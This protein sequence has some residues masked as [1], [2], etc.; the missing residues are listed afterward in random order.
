MARESAITLTPGISFAD[1]ESDLQAALIKK[2][3][4]SH[5]FHDIPEIKPAVRPIAPVKGY[6]TEAEFSNAFKKYE[7]ELGKWK[8]GE[9]EAKNVLLRR[10]SPSVR[11]QDFRRMIAKQIFDNIATP[12][13]E[14]AAT[15]YENSVRN[16]I[17]IKF[18][19]IE[20]Y[21]DKFMQHYL[22]VN[23]AAESMV[24][25]EKLQDSL[26]PFSIPH[27][28][29]SLLFLLGTEN[30]ERLDTWIQTKILDNKNKYVSLELM[31]LS[32][33]QVGK[34]KEKTSEKVIVATGI[35]GKEKVKAVGG[36]NDTC[37]LCKHKNK[38]CFRQHPELR[39]NKR[40]RK[41]KANSKEK[42]SASVAVLDDNYTSD[43]SEGI[44]VSKLARAST[45]NLMKNSLL[46]DTGASRH[47]IRS[48][49]DF[50]TL[51]KLKK[52]P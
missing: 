48:V 19:I 14:G 38:K 6:K 33:R 31:M 23:S 27:G 50:V 43:S 49:S 13:E 42:S 2:G 32:F 39:S 41:N 21:C 15:P 17:N 22:S 28:L 30:F 12:R 7:E 18:T 29:A 4:L 5:I 20:E 3:R 34:S 26:N 46:Y 8:E 36:P 45:A 24:S 1:W 10:L 37:V 35:G 44:G 47:F 25:A 40:K 16:L 51:D 9:I 52:T 11:P